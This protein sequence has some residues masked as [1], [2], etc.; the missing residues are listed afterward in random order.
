MPLSLGAPEYEVK[1]EISGEGH[2]V[3]FPVP[4]GA[5]G[6]DIYTGYGDDMKLVASTGPDGKFKI[7]KQ[8]ITTSY[9]VTR[10][11]PNPDTQQSAL[12]AYGGC[13]TETRSSRPS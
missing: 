1:Y 12:Q 13:P 7:P 11:N 4:E 2:T 6:L 3:R 8:P 10:T 5:A 9:I